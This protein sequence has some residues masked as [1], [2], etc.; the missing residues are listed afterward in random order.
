MFQP[1]MI[2]QAS[3]YRFS[4]VLLGLALTCAAT[5][6]GI[7]PPSYVLTDLTQL[8]GLANQPIDRVYAFNNKGQIVFGNFAAGQTFLYSGGTV[9]FLGSLGGT[10][11]Q[12][13]AINDTGEVV[14]GADVGNSQ[15]HAFLYA[16]GQTQDL[17]TLGGFNSFAAGINQ[18]G[19][20]TGTAQLGGVGDPPSHAFLY[21]GGKMH[22]LGDLAGLGSNGTAINDS[23]QIAGF[24]EIYITGAQHA[25]LYSGGNMKDLGTLGGL[26]SLANAM[27]N[28]GQVVG[29]SETAGGVFHA[30]LYSNETMQ[31]LGTLGG[32]SDAVGINDAGEIVGVSNVNDSRHAFLYTDG[33]MYDL[34]NLVTSADGDTFYDAIGI[35]AGGQIIGYA[36]TPSGNTIEALLTPSAVPLPPASGMGL[37]MIGLI[38][39]G[40]FCGRLRRKAFFNVSST[41]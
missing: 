7:A 41:Y 32:T 17:G 12:A 16:G 2:L 5:D 38:A 8:P 21:S 20:I 15:Q 29:N 22:D 9:Q 14:G 27:N 35:N 30:F 6:A 1:R 36:R 31:D 24:S 37:G 10:S 33:T 34:S 19:Q 40:A 28:S 23:G 11:S 13:N 39:S 26:D 4:W 18:S 3:V 25:F